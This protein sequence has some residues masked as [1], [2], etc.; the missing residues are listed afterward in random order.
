MIR[1]VLKAALPRGLAQMVRDL[2]RLEPGARWTFLVLALRRR[3]G[4][5][6]APMLPATRSIGLVAICHG[7]ILRSAYAAALLKQPAVAT[8]IPQLRVSSAGLHAIPGKSADRRGV[9]A[10]GERGIDLSAHRATL[11]DER[12]VDGADLLVVM[13]HLNVAE[14]VSR[15]PGAAHK[16]VLLGAFD[17]AWTPDP[18]IP[19][20]Y[21]GNLD[22]VRA[23]Y[24][25]VA[26][27]VEGLVARLSG[28]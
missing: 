10:A 26:A 4:R 21:G 28:A 20:P 27:A 25:R 14:V 23:S 22:A 17:P 3:L 7:N 6:R 19:D 9:E 15:Y 13:D 12:I 2:L 1:S 18:A 24:D 16:V 5:D 11:L 8:R